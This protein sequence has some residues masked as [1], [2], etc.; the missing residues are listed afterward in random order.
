MTAADANDVLAALWRAAEQP[1]AAMDAIELTGAEPALPSSFAVGTAAPS[2]RIRRLG[3]TDPKTT[4]G[5]HFWV[6]PVPARVNHSFG[7]AARTCASDSPS[8]RRTILVPSTSA[9]HL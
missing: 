1:A 7:S 5:N 3:R 8:S 4:G 2:G 9:T 6:D